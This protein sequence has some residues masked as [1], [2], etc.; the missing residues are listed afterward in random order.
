MKLNVFGDVACVGVMGAGSI[1]GY[2]EATG[3]ALKLPLH[4]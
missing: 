2:E 3:V 4:L 1:P